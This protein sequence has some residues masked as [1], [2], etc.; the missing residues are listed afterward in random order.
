[1]TLPVFWRRASFSVAEAAGIAAVSE[2]QL[3]GWL[4]RNPSN[5]FAGAKVGSR[6][7]FS[8]QDIFYYRLVRELT[9]F[10]VSVRVAFRTA[11]IVADATDDEL[12]VE[13]F[14]IATEYGALHDFRHTDEPDID[15]RTSLVIPVRRL[16]EIAIERARAVFATEGR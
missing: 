4:A 14:L 6:L 13:K 2:E 15:Y 9:R 1:M 8:G 5:T 11:E 3:R 16:A 12:P 10:G 7:F